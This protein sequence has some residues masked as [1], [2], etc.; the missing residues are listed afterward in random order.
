MHY[1]LC[2]IVNKTIKEGRDN[3]KDSLITLQSSKI[4][5]NECDT[6]KTE[7]LMGST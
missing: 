7:F 3:L 2:E 6:K 5:N 4:S 1:M